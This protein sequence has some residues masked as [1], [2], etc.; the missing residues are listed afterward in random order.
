MLGT[1]G[2]AQQDNGPG[3]LITDRPDA[4]EA[5]NTVG[6]G[7]LQFETGAFFTREEANGLQTESTTF[8]T[9]LV[10]YGI[11][12]NFELRLGWNF[13]ETRF[14]FNGIEAPDVLSGL[15]P[16]LLGA[17]VAITEE[18]GLIPD[19]G[20][21]GHVFLPFT[22]GR[23]YKPEY[24][25]VDFRF[26]FAHT[27]SERSSLSYNLGAQWGGD[28]PEAEYIYTLAYGYAI[29]DAFGFYLEL[30]GELPEDSGP[31]HLWDAGVTYLV[32]D[33]LQLDATIGSGIRSDQEL[34]LS[35]GLSYR[36]DTRKSK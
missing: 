21:I 8:N 33:D 11:F 27:L 6:T 19:I 1:Y 25:G 5:P 18:Q 28:N 22:A 32:N 29:T 2:Y 17:K 7:F 36:I 14:E 24:T 15:D 13:T 34:L 31:N 3:P 4:T 26:S 30:Y 23:D 12:D 16:L 10:R 9:M 20:L 35:A